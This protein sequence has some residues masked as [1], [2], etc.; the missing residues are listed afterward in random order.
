MRLMSEL[1]LAAALIL[2]GMVSACQP[3]K[4]CHCVQSGGCRCPLPPPPKNASPS[5][6]QPGQTQATTA[7]HVARHGHETLREYAVSAHEDRLGHRHH[8]TRRHEAGTEAQ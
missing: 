3:T 7:M 6:E 4:P 8:R 2:A 5:K 1:S